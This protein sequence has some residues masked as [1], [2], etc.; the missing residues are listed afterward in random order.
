M[1]NSAEVAANR[2]AKRPVIL[3]R[4]EVLADAWPA[5]PGTFK[6]PAYIKSVLGKG[7]Y[8]GKHSDSKFSGWAALFFIVQ[9]AYIRFINFLFTI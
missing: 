7:D 1:W 5:L 2:V 6:I 4:A 9:L 8:L 3:I